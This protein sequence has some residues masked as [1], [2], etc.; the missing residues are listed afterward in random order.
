MKNSLKKSL[1]VGMAALGFIAAAGA[2]NAQSASAKTYAKVAT[3]KQLT[4]DATT[5]NVTLNGS[6]ALYTKAGTLKGAR[7]V[8]SKTTLKG[9]VSSKTSSKANFRAYRVATTNRG[10]VYYK[11][12]SFDGNYRGWVY[13]GKDTTA[14]NGG[15]ASVDT[16]KEGKVS[17]D[18]TATTWK[19]ATVGTAND[20]K[21]VTYKAPAWT[22]YKVGRQI[23]DSTSLKDATFKIT[24][25]G[26]RTNEGDTW[27]YVE[28]TDS[29][30]ANANG[31]VLASGLVKADAA[32]PAATKDNSVNVV[33]LDANGVQV[34]TKTF[35]TTSTTAKQ[36]TVANSN[37]VNVKGESLSKFAQNNVP[38]GYKFSAFQNTDASFGNTQYVK[39]VKAATSK[40]S[41]SYN[42]TKGSTAAYTLSS[43][44]FN[45]GYPKLN[46]DQQAN[47]TSD[48]TSAFGSD[49]FTKTVAGLFKGEKDG[50]YFGQKI[51]NNNGYVYTYA[52][53]ATAT[54]ALNKDKKPGEA[55]QLVFTRSE[56][57][58]AS[59]L[60]SSTTETGN[61]NYV[62]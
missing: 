6:N 2:A 10:S 20:G 29:K 39:V 34:G 7:V 8:A 9:L 3:N 50:Y 53:D 24:K 23:T 13:G 40:V 51:A 60:P 16:F 31:W 15:L 47:F 56:N 4:T 48:S 21:Q 5:R 1:F 27:V 22:Q 41:F 57:V 33:Y 62:G 49:F 32:D 12:V 52:Y 18:Q 30:N 55:I 19:F 46:A 61:T 42:T 17:A 38:A 54:A 14:F 58:K 45:S 25:T 43:S 59:E 44:D 36:N 11:V 26:T 37:F 28:A 35:V